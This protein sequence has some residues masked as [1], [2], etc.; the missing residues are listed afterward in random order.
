MLPLREERY[1]A[2][3]ELLAAG[4]PFDPEALDLDRHYV[5]LTTS[6]AVFIFESRLGADALEPLLQEPKLWQSVAAW[7]DYLAGPPRI[8]EDIF[9]WERSDIETDID[10][11]LLIPRPPERR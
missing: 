10:S 1:D 11:S 7:H 3:R 2:V 4:P 6:E 5:F 9:S 8:A